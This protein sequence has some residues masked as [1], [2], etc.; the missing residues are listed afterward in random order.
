MKE[1]QKDIFAIINALAEEINLGGKLNDEI[2]M[3]INA[4][5]DQFL[6]FIRKNEYLKKIDSLVRQ[7]IEGLIEFEFSPDYT[8]EE[9]N[10]LFWHIGHEMW[11]RVGDQWKNGKLHISF[12]ADFYHFHQYEKYRYRLKGVDK[13]WMKP[14][15]DSDCFN[16]ND[17][18]DGKYIEEVKFKKLAEEIKDFFEKKHEAF[19][20]KTIEEVIEEC[21]NKSDTNSN[22]S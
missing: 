6:P 13:D 11:L 3:K 12:Y 18:R 15:I 14:Y 7:K 16:F 2:G 10:V 22:E 8:T 1:I 19:G 4:I 17:F 5:E 21:N 20:N 9:Q